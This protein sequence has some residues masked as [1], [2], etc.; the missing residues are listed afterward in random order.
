MQIGFYYLFFQYL[1]ILLFGDF[2]DSFLYFRWHIYIKKC[3]LT[4]VR[5]PISISDLISD[6]CNVVSFQFS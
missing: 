6:V 4:N 1:K 3:N 2:M 5:L